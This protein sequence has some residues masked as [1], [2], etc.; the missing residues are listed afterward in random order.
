MRFQLTYTDAFSG[1]RKTVS[2]IASSITAFKKRAVREYYGTLYSVVHNDV[3]ILT[4]KN[5]NRSSN[6]KQTKVKKENDAAKLRLHR[7]LYS[8][9][10]AYLNHLL[11]EM[12]KV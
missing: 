2:V 12:N 4:K 3:E 11:N 10:I 8:N 9:D 5:A 7:S 6:W 1:T